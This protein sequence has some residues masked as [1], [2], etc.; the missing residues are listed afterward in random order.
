MAAKDTCRFAS[1]LLASLSF[2]LLLSNAVC[3]GGKTLV[4]L[5]NQFIKETHS[6]FFN[7]LRGKFSFVHYEQKIIGRSRCHEVRPVFRPEILMNLN[8]TE[9]M[10]FV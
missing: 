7:F 3:T 5:D 9:T 1:T 6:I 4:L 2:C 10:A 8:F